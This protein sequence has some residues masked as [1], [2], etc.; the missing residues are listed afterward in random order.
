MMLALPICCSANRV[1]SSRRIG[2]ATFR[3]VAV[4]F[5]AADTHPDHDTVAT[6]RRE[7]QAA[8]ASVLEMARELALFKVGMVSVDGTGIDA[9][10]SKIRSVRYGRAR[11]LRA[12]PEAD[13]AAPM[14][15]AEAEAADEAGAELDQRRQGAIENHLPSN[16]GWIGGYVVLCHIAGEDRHIRCFDLSGMAP[17]CHAASHS[18]ISSSRPREPGGFVKSGSR[19]HPF[20]AASSS[21]PGMP[22]TRLRISSK[23]RPVSLWSIKG[24]S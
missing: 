19:L 1:F 14:A 2:K 23:G 16:G 12:Q 21:G 4:R 24:L 13:I 22:L 7:R 15:R 9:N 3:D 11:E 18:A 20:A 5:V 17:P 6:F 10:A 8:F